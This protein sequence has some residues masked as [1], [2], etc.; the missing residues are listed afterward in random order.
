MSS[1]MPDSAQRS[2]AKRRA[3]VALCAK[4]QAA[5]VNVRR[6]ALATR[7]WEAGGG[8]SGL[9][10][11]KKAIQGLVDRAGAVLTTQV[12]RLLLE[13]LSRSSLAMAV[14]CSDTSL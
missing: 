14:A 7:K 9:S 10:A 1:E 12:A 3:A 4:G 5:M 11:L 2:T 13:R 8:V 6:I